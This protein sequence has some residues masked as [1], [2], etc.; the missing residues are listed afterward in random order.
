[1]LTFSSNQNLKVA[2][3]DG[4]TVQAGWHWSC[5]SKYSKNSRKIPNVEY[6]TLTKVGSA[7]KMVQDAYLEVIGK[8]KEDV[9]FKK[10]VICSK[11][12]SCGKSLNLEDFPRI[13]F[14]ESGSQESQ[15]VKQEHWHFTATFCTNSWRRNRRVPQEMACV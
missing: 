8:Q 14:T 3:K 2:A 5:A 4:K 10:Q 6:F 11:H 15:K 9:N 1:M 7:P 12:C 13:K